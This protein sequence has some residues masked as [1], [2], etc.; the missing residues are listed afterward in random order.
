MAAQHGWSAPV[1][2][3]ALNTVGADTGAHIS[4]DGLTMHWASSVSGNWEIYSATRTARGAPWGAPVLETVLSDPTAVDSE[5]F[6]SADGLTIYFASQRP[7]GTGS[8]DIMRA[9]RPNPTAPWGQPTF[10]TE[11]NS[12]GADAAPAVTEDEL[13]IYFLTTG[14]NAP[15]PPQNAI[16]VAKRQSTALPFGTPQIVAEL[17]S[18]N[19]HR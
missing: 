10:V 2:I 7:G 16:A 1:P 6:L 18:P 11:L 9:T 5:P 15:N 8:T 3:A 17:A 13:E 4:P 19:T 12:S 14:W